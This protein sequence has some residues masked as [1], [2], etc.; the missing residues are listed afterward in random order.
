MAESEWEAGKIQERMEMG[1]KQPEGDLRG[2]QG[3]RDYG[4]L[5]E[6]D[7]PDQSEGYCK[8]RLMR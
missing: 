3:A 2:K 8:L 5:A 7:Q 4:E 1:D 6:Q